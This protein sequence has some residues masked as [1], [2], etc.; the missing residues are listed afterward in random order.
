MIKTETHQ[1]NKYELHITLLEPVELEGWKSSAIDGDPLLGDGVKYYLT[2][3]S[4]SEE[5]GHDKINQALDVLHN[6]KVIRAKIEHIV[7]DVRI[8][9]EA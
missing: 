5:Q 2:T 9:N 7:Y 6:K 4:V 3:Y 8:T 1:Q